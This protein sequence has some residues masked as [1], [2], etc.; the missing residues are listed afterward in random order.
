M[1]PE[2]YEHSHARIHPR[3]WIAGAAAPI[4]APVTTVVTLHQPARPVP[5][6]VTETLACFADSRF[7]PVPTDIVRRALNTVLAAWP[8][9]PV[10][11]RCH[12]GLNRSALIVGLALHQAGQPATD[13]VAHLRHV[14]PGALNN[15]YFADLVATWPN[16]PMRAADPPD[17]QPPDASTARRPNPPDVVDDGGSP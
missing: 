7:Q 12:H 14:R 11:V 1:T 9:R 4:P 6:T 3:M 5:A 13:V 15:P 16:D 8:H 10:L 17:G 2:E